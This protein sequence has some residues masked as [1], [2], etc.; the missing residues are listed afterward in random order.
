MPNDASETEF[1]S[2]LAPLMNQFVRE[3][4]ACGYAYHE[5][6]RILHRL[7]DFLVQERLTTLELPRS[8]TRKWLAK[9]RTKVRERSGTGSLSFATSPGSCCERVIPRTCPSPRWRLGIWQLLYP[10]C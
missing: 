6:T 7:D 4:H 9:K 3:K 2:V 10:E 1:Q 5:P 8:L